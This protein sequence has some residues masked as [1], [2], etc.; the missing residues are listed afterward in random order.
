[1]LDTSLD[2]HHLLLHR[3]R[4]RLGGPRLHRR[5]GRG[6]RL[7]LWLR[8]PAAR[9]HHEPEHHGC[10]LKV[11]TFSVPSMV[12]GPNSRVRTGS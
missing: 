10:S 5:H 12:G 11:Q 3:A 7:R 6:L 1:M 8:L 4:H 2:A 9:H